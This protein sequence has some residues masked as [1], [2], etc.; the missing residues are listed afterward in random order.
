M[1][2]QTRQPAGTPTGG[3]FAAAARTEPGVALAGDAR[4]QTVDR[5]VLELIDA[6]AVGEDSQEIGYHLTDVDEVASIAAWTAL[7]LPDEVEPDERYVAVAREAI[8]DTL[9]PDE[10]GKFWT[11]QDMYWTDDLYGLAGSMTDAVL[12]ARDVPAAA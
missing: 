1:S 4:E 12:A 8:T 3:Q 7:G 11:G 2:T 5:V 6:H 9:T 10:Q